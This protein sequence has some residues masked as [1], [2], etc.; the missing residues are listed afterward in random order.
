MPP[1]INAIWKGAIIMRKRAA[2]PRRAVLKSIG[3]IALITAIRLI[4]LELKL[5]FRRNHAQNIPMSIGVNI[6]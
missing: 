3:I 2:G 6:N 1:K 5:S 4:V